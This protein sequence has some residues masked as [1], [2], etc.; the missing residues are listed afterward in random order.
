MTKQKVILYDDNCPL[1][2]WYTGAF[3][4]TGL[5]P[6]DGR[7][8]FSALDPAQLHTQLDIDRSKDEIPLLDTAGGETIYGVDSLLYILGQRWPWMV[9][10]ANW[11]PMNW[12]IRR[13]YKFVSYNR[14]VIVASQTPAGAFD[15]SPQFN[16][17][18]RYLYL[19]F[20][21]LLGSLGAWAFLRAQALPDDYMLALLPVLLGLVAP[22]IGLPNHAA[23]L[24]YLGI[25]LTPYLLIGL[26]LLLFLWVPFP[27]FV[28][29]I[30]LMISGRM[31]LR[32]WGVAIDKLM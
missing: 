5:L 26:L 29:A 8:S 7:Q 28:A 3:V 30:I 14:R 17:F 4:K 19:A 27:A 25:M 9:K 32:R 1:C 2:C 15:C 31:W 11:P 6:P 24:R 10:V 12:L 13:F 22:I 18:Y 21:L 20:A 16:Y 23:R